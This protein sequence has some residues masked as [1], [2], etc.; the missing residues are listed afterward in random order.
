M[1]I[2]EMELNMS[3][4]EI[5]AETEPQNQAKKGPIVKQIKNFLMKNFQLVFLELVWKGKSL[6][7]KIRLKLKGELV[8]L[9]SFRMELNVS[10]AAE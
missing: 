7:I 4:N 1:N 8:M 2:L 10:I 3:G 6:E 9:S 5:K